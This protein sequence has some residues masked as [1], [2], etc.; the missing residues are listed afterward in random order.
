VLRAGVARVAASS[1]VALVRRIG[2]LL[3]EHV[4][5]QEAAVYPVLGAAA[6]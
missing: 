6:A 5:R 3:R 4:E 2:A 1:D